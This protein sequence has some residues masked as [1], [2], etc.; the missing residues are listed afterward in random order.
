MCLKE[1]VGTQI[2]L[3]LGAYLSRS[4]SG[5]I[6]GLATSREVEDA[7]VEGTAFSL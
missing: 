4:T 1:Q 2:Q 3:D 6:S 7:G 5:G